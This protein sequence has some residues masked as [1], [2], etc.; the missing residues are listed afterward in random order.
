[1]VEEHACS[2]MTDDA[3]DSS[4]KVTNREWLAR[5]RARAAKHALHIGA[6]AIALAW[7]A[8]S[9]AAMAEAPMFS[10]DTLTRTIVITDDDEGS[11]RVDLSVSPDRI[12]ED[13]GAQVLTLTATLNGTARS[14]ATAVNVAVSGGT[15]EATVDYTV[16]SSFT[17]T[18]AQGD[19][20]A[21]RTFRFQPVDDGIDEG[22]ETVEIGATATNL[23]TRGATITIID[24]DDRGVTA[25]TSTLTVAE[26]RTGTYTVVL[27]TQPTGDVTVRAAEP[28]NDFETPTVSIY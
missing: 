24:N 16:D 5:A 20:S 10:D 7:V 28:V 1:M 4:I 18:I 17:I 2:A 27:N 11:R 8:T 9:P 12:D 26:G 25:S 19:I 6:G 3:R 13:A 15:A 14:N 22:D 23:E 21:N